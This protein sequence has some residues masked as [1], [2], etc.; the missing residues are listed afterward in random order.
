MDL[1]K[2]LFPEGPHT[3][4]LASFFFVLPSVMFMI[5]TQLPSLAFSGQLNDGTGPLVEPSHSSHPMAQPFENQ[6]QACPFEYER[7][8]PG[9]DSAADAE[10]YGQKFSNLTFPGLTFWIQGSSS[11]STALRGGGNVT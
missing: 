7:L 4:S 3:G 8:R 10:G 1:P 6:K 11:E 9:S 5:G 2:L